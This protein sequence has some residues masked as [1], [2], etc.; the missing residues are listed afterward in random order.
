M[1]ACLTRLL[2][3]APTVLAC[4]P[5]LA[6]LRLRLDL[7]HRLDLGYRCDVTGTRERRARR[8][9]KHARLHRRGWLARIAITTRRRHDTNREPTICSRIVNIDTGIVISGQQ[10]RR[11]RDERIPTVHARL[12][13]M[14]FETARYIRNRINMTILI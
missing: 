8:R 4:V 7:H 12:Q 13:E 9:T 3:H 14:R 2:P 6:S 5:L 11:G 1:A 10:L